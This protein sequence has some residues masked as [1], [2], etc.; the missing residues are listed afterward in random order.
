MFI[1]IDTKD[2]NTNSNKRPKRRF[3]SQ[4]YDEND[5]RKGRPVRRFI[6]VELHG[7]GIDQIIIEENNI[8]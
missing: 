4:S 3:S 7:T 1:G 2:H 8:E 6:I 5:F